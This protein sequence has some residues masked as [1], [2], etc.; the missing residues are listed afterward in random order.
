MKEYKILYLAEVATPDNPDALYRKLYPKDDGWYTLDSDGNEL[1]IEGIKIVDENDTVFPQKAL[2]KFGF[3]FT[4]REE[5]DKITIT[6]F[7][8]DSDTSWMF[9]H[10]N[11][12]HD[13]A[14]AAA[15]DLQ[16]HLD[17]TEPHG[18][19]LENLHEPN[20]DQYLDFGGDNEVS[21]E[22]IKALLTGTVFKIATITANE[23]NVGAFGVYLADTTSNHVKLV[24]PL[25]ATSENFE[26]TFRHVKGTNAMN[27]ERSEMDVIMWN[28]QAW[29]GITTDVKGTWFTLKC[30]GVL[31]HVTIDSGLTE[32]NEI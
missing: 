29:E 27:V 24:L 31:W 11:E 21:V 28:D 15:S 25:A 26:F 19:I 7:D 23:T 8:E 16:D 12:F 18:I 30:D 4:V 22:E 32:A 13:P 9:T 10:G 14:F 1:K 20:T 6:L 2:L 3:P 5:G 17:D